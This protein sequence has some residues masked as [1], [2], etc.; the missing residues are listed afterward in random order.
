MEAHLCVWVC[1]IWCWSL[2]LVVVMEHVF[3]HI[4]YDLCP[5]SSEKVVMCSPF[6]KSRTDEW[7]YVALQLS[8]VP[9]AIEARIC[10]GQEQARTYV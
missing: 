4:L 2:P 10:T 6:S 5:Y 8:K 9:G 7:Y 1:Q 3:S